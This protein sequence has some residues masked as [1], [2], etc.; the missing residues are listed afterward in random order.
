MTISLLRG[1]QLDVL[2]HIHEKGIVHCD[3]KPGNFIFGT[4][5]HAGRLHLID[6]G[7][8]RPWADPSTGKPFP[9]DSICWQFDEPTP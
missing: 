5:E 6:F 2:E 3:I 9:E 4:G 8:S 7:L 1:P